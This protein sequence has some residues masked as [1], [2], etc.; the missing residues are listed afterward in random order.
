MAEGKG[1]TR[2][3]WAICYPENM[4]E[5][6]KD[7]IG[8][9]LQIPYAYCVHDKDKDEVGDNRGVHVHIMI[10]F[11]NTTT[12][13]HALSVFELLSKEN[14]RCVNTCKKII[15][16]RR[17]FDYLIHDTD[18]CKKKK[19]HLYKKEER[20]TG[21]NFDIGAYEQIGLEEKEAIR[22]ELSFLAYEKGFVSYAVMYMYVCSNFDNVY[23]SIMV[24][25]QGHFDKICKG[26]YHKREE[27]K[28]L[29]EKDNEKEDK[30]SS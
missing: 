5:T 20:I 26:N 28:K 23:E 30:K 12:Y 3:W 15:S 8:D 17:A 16:V 27:Q 25:Y 2:Y 1:K 4:I 6:W 24:T 10:A 9:L 21:N 11:P 7:D 29:A 22:R 14:A 18:E 19:K 13:K